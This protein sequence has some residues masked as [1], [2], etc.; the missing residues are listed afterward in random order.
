MK[1]TL[2]IILNFVVSFIS[3]LI[4][5]D[6]S[7]KKIIDTRLIIIQ[8]LNHYF[9]DKSVV[10]TAFFAGLTIILSLFFTTFISKILFNFYIPTNI[11]T[12]VIFNILSFILGYII[13]IVI[14]KTKLFGKSLE[15]YYKV[16]GSGFWGAIA[17]LFSINLSYL[18][19]NIICIMNKNKL[20][21]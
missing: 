2:F 6:L 10:I 8:E 7:F 14:D 18:I 21:C 11:N 4:L 20:M 1:Y 15:P 17:Y 19:G 5:N 13:D 3:D 9:K 16:A 12:L